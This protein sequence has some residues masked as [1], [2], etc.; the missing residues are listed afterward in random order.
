MDIPW[1][2]KSV[3]WWHAMS[4]QQTDKP[5]IKIGKEGTGVSSILFFLPSEKSYAPI[6]A[7]FVKKDQDVPDKKMEYIVH[8]DGAHF[9]SEQLKQN[10]ITFSDE[11]LNKFGFINSPKILDRI[12]SFQYDA[13]VD[14]NQSMDQPLSLLALE[15]DI[16]MK[17]GFQSPIADQLYTLVIEPS[18]SGFLEK[19]YETIERLLGLV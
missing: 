13:L 19:S 6:A 5:L 14:L 4:K 12:K 8:E 18:P 11:D 9:Y 10:L 17:I 2:I 15:L 7:Y 16:S 3:L 1:R